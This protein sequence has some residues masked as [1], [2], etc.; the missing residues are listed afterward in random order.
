MIPTIFFHVPRLELVTTFTSSPATQQPSP[1]QHCTS[2]M[3]ANVCLRAGSFIS[4]SEN[5]LTNTVTPS[6]PP[7]VATLSTQFM[8]EL[9]RSNCLAVAPREITGRMNCKIRQVEIK[10]IAPSKIS[11]SAQNLWKKH[12]EEPED[13]PLAP[14][15]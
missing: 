6:W 5:S 1:V 2:H 7:R 13:L 15:S 9:W 11:R 14:W 10:E 4:R 3:V 12:S 8:R